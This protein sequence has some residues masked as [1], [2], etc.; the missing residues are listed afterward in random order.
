[1]CPRYVWA[2]QQNNIIAEASSGNNIP[3]SITI[4]IA[5]S[6]NSFEFSVLAEYLSSLH[7][8][9]QLY[10]TLVSTFSILDQFSACLILLYNS[11]RLDVVMN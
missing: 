1:L 3:P 6:W 9:F 10:P 7:S 8:A 11:L 5:S 4:L 2:G